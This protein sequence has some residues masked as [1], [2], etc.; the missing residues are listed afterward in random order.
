M[1]TMVIIMSP[2][3]LQ[4]QSESEHS[5]ICSIYPALSRIRNNTKSS[6]QQ[7]VKIPMHTCPAQSPPHAQSPPV[8]L[9]V[10]FTGPSQAF[11]I[12]IY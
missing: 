2:E 8:F 6:N 5:V 3:T 10:A 7:I 1:F 11:L 4:R 12:E 9:H